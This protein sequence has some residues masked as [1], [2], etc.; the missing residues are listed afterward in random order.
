M[1]NFCLKAG[2]FLVTVMKWRISGQRY[3]HLTRFSRFA[4]FESAASTLKVCSYASCYLKKII[5]IGFPEL[6]KNLSNDFALFLSNDCL[7]IKVYLCQKVSGLNISVII[8]SKAQSWLVLNLPVFMFVYIHFNV[9][10]TRIRSR[11]NV[12]NITLNNTEHLLSAKCSER[13]TILFSLVHPCWVLFSEVWLR[14]NFSLNKCLATQHF[15][16]F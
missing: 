2:I 9:P 5:K 10:P 3:K 8:I 14:S 1:F 12:L 11:S 16:C 7:S 4:L 6:E 13:L 15:L